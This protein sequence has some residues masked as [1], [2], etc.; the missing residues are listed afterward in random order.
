MLANRDRARSKGQGDVQDGGI[1]CGDSISSPDMAIVFRPQTGPV[2]LGREH[3]HDTRPDRAAP[4][5]EK[6]HAVRETRLYPVQSII[7]VVTCTL[8]I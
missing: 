5:E 8:G 4:A 1:H 7:T 6:E 3:D 2:K